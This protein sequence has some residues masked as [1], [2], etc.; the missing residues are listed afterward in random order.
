MHDG[1]WVVLL[2]DAQRRGETASPHSS[3]QI[4]PSLVAADIPF[5]CEHSQINCEHNQNHVRLSKRVP[6]V[7]RVKFSCLAVLRGAPKMNRCFEHAD[8]SPQAKRKKDMNIGLRVVC[9]LNIPRWKAE[10]KKTGAILFPSRMRNGACMLM[11]IPCCIYEVI[12]CN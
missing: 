5:R 12:E 2:I 8:Q 9:G 6:L 3:C 1:C 11:R 4:P 10:T 7:Q